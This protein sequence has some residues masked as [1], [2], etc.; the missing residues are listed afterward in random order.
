MPAA[1]VVA[2]AWRREPHLDV[3][4]TRRQA[5]ARLARVTGLMVERVRNDAA[6]AYAAAHD[7]LTGLANRSQFYTALEELATGGDDLGIAYLDL[8]GFKP[9]N[10]VLG[11]GVGDA[12]LAAVARRLEHAAPDGAVVARLGGDEFAVVC[13]GA[14]VDELV[15]MATALV[16]QVA[17]P[18]ELGTASP[19][20]V[21]ASAG[22]AVG[23]A[24]VDADAIVEA[25]AVALYEAKRTGGGAV[26]V[27][28]VRPR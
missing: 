26:R 9:I 15:G 23:P 2:V 6:T 25:A 10:D 19:V 21:A 12:V 3:D 4:Q 17:R 7:E 28:E 8:D 16:E 22:V 11:H 20:R 18:V 13:P 27:G 14:T 1:D 24:G 5:M